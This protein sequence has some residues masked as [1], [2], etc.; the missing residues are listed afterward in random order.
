MRPAALLRVGFDITDDGPSGYR[1][2]YYSM[3]RENGAYTWHETLSDVYKTAE[4]EFQIK[5]DEWEPA[6]DD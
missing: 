4:E 5:R 1:L 2:I 6:E 3:D